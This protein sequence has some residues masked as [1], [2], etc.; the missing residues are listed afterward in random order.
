LSRGDAENAEK[1]L[2]PR[3]NELA[4]RVIGAAIEV[5][6]VLGPGYLE[7][8][9][10]EAMSIELQAAEV[11]FERQKPIRLS[12]KGYDVGQSRLDFL[13]G[14]QLVLELKAANKLAPIHRAQLIAYL[15]ATGCELGLVINFNERA[16]REGIMRVALSVRRQ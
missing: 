2:D 5:H 14:G 1:N 11:P 3:L 10:E 9:Y 7:S 4:T 12:Y 16:L 8:V 15:K 6:R 13:V